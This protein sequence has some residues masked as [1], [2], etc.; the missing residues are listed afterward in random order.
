LHRLAQEKGRKSIF[1][2][3]RIRIANVTRDY[4]LENREQA[5]DDSKIFHQ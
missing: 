5:P 3:Y 1:E 4:S 2:D